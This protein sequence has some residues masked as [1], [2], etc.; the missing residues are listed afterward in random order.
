MATTEERIRKLVDENLEI[1]G[2]PLGRELDLN[3]S[4]RDAGVPSADFVAFT[5]V[6]AEEFNLT[7]TPEDCVKF[8]SLGDLVTHL[9]S[10]G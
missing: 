9:D 6:V 10:R 3:S 5:K 4:L 1:E 7:F 8:Q 2:R